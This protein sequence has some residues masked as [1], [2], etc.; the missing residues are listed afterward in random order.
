[1]TQ[2]FKEYVKKVKKYMVNFDGTIFS[3][4]KIKGFL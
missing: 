1:M 4:L 2:T 3:R